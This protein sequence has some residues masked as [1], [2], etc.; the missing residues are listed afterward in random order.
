M[1]TIIDG[2]AVAASVRERAAADVRELVTLGVTPHL[3]VVLVGDDPA[4]ASYVR[5]KE[6]DCEQVGIVSLDHRLPA[7]TTQ[8]E[9]DALIDRLNADPAVH[10]IL[11]QMPLP[12]HLDAE[13]VI[14]RIAPAKDVDGFHPESLG[15]L[16]RGL[17][18][19]RACTPAGVMELLRAYDIDPKGM[20]AVVIGRSTIVGKP[21]ALLLLEANATVTVCHSRT[22]DLPGVCREADLLVAAIG[23]AGMIDASY[24]K[25]GAVVIDVGI[26]RT[27]AG[28]VGDVDYASVE[29]IASAITPVPGG[30]G[31]MTRA[32]LMVNTVRAARAV[33]VA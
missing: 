20:R 32:M 30:V 27:D 29:P 15:L 3:A 16:V 7:A 25:L 17:P 4:S 26:N 19:F 12:G 10:G 23:R 5:M 14:E 2:V 6:R 24:V 8:V 9:L 13:S 1:A 11:V 28:L 22:V 21:M 31:P 33:A 18:G